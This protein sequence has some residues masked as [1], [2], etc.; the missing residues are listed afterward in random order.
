MHTVRVEG[1]NLIYGNALGLGGYGG[2]PT[3]P[4]GGGVYAY[5]TTLTVTNCKVMSNTAQ[6]VPDCGCTRPTSTFRQTPSPTTTRRLIR[7][8]GSACGGLY[9]TNGGGTISGNDISDNSA[10][11]GGG[12]FLYNTSSTVEDNVITFNHAGANYGGGL[13]I[14]DGS[15]QLNRNLIQHNWAHIRGGGVYLSHDSSTGTTT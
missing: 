11:G 5:Q 7:S 9:L 10:E 12:L 15:P 2:Y 13:Y 14:V 1:L 8:F 6:Y 4:P 3:I